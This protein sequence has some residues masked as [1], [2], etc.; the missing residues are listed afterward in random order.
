[1]TKDQKIFS[2]RAQ[3]RRFKSDARGNFAA[4]TGLLLV[5]L[6][7]MGGLALDHWKASS[8]RADLENAADAA[9]LAAINR[10][11]AVL[12]MATKDAAAARSAGVEAA[13]SQFKANAGKVPDTGVAEP[14]INVTVTGLA[15]S[16][17]VTWKAV[18]KSNFS[19]LVGGGDLELSGN[20]QSSLTLPGYVKI[21]FLVDNSAS[22][23]I[24]AS[25]DGQVRLY[26]K[27]H[28]AIACHLDPGAYAKQVYYSVPGYVT[29]Y[30]Y[31]REQGIDTRI[32]VVRTGLS[33]ILDKAK[34]IRTKPD[35][36]SIGLYTFSADPVELIAPTTNLDAVKTAV[37]GL[38]LTRTG[39]ST[40]VGTTMNY[41]ANKI[42]SGSRGDGSSVEKPQVYVLFVTDGVSANT[43]FDPTTGNW[44]RDDDIKPFAPTF[45]NDI[46]GLDPFLCSPVKNVSGVTL[47]P[48]NIEY[49][50]PK[51]NIRG[52]HVAGRFPFIET[53]ILPLQDQRFKQ[54]GSDGVYFKS[55]TPEEILASLNSM[56]EHTIP[57]PPRL[58]Q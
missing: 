58:S 34:Q 8:A 7:G 18:T 21:Y 4:L 39:G 43:T 37:G 56:F 5:P 24:A 50:V 51:P 54:C 13:V 36:F 22:M 33:Q 47:L 40:D 38:A 11:A 55:R 30:S 26:D 9:A 25:E 53:N 35:Q 46:S 41:I 31:A 17:Q 3:A 57:R 14:S 28:C 42:R 45:W 23:G 19:A 27:I 29:S 32:D 10:A 15:I 1:M 6:V 44:P 16:A 48:L 12:Q 49:I 20:S 52:D 2:L